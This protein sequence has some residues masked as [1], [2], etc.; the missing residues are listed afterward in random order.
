MKQHFIG[1]KI[2]RNLLLGIIVEL[3]SQSAKLQ[4]RLKQQAPEEVLRYIEA[5]ELYVWGSC[6]WHANAPR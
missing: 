1:A 5:L 3:E 2:A 4:E 6:Y